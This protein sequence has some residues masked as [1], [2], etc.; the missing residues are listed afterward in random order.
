MSMS[1]ME[2]L[3]DQLYG[4]GV[5]LIGEFKLSSGI[6]SPYYIDLRR[7]YSYP[8]LFKDIIKLYLKTLN[9]IEGKFDIIV[10]IETGS[11]PIASVL[12]YIMGRP[13]AYVRK[14]TKEYGT[15]KL[16]EGSIDPEDRCIIVD[17]VATTGRSIAR[18]A[19]ILRSLN[20]KV[21][22]AVVFIDREQGAEKV[23][24]NMGIKL[25][26]ILKVSRLLE[27]LWRLKLINRNTYLSILSY[28]GRSGGE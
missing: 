8:K 22:Y 17:D 10:G 1:C 12:S 2:K 3:V 16:I 7:I 15:E 11:I 24:D 14:T 6:K 20:A 21:D 27:I 23:L 18:A 19:T 4:H 28:M 13:M 25:L 9:S 5:V 26:S